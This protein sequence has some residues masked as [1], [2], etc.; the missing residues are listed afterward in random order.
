MSDGTILAATPKPG[1]TT[2]DATPQHSY[3]LPSGA[4]EFIPLEEYVRQINSGYADWMQSWLYRNV[5][6][7]YDEN[8]QLIN[9]DLTITGLA[10]ASD[11]F[12]VIAAGIDTDWWDLDIN[13]YYYSYFLTDLWN[14]QAGVKDIKEAEINS[15]Y[16]PVYNLQGVMVKDL[17]GGDT[18][19]TLPKGIYIL[20]GRKIFVGK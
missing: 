3:V 18:L 5:P 17:Q 15:Q 11:D 9:I 20:N 7:G 14:D 12:N 2:P 13:Y 6:I 10:T 19:E 1:S 8:G 16:G 4:E